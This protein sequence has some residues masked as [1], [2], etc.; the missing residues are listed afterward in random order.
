VSNINGIL[1]IILSLQSPGTFTNDYTNRFEISQENITTNMSTQ[2][3][4]K[5]PFSLLSTVHY[6]H[7][8]SLRKR[9]FTEYTNLEFVIFFG[10]LGGVSSPA[11]HPS[12]YGA[13]APS[14]PWPPSKRASTR[15]CF[16]PFSSILLLLAA[17]NSFSLYPSRRLFIEP[18]RGVFEVSIT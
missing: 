14:G 9:I 3:F 15:P 18:F 2:Y 12:M 7:P 10:H 6:K 1:S 13:T 16:Q 8:G 11:I 5:Y 17:V 4:D